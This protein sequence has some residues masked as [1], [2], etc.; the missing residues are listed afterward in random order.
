V[1]DHGY[2]GYAVIVNKKFW[3]GLPPDIRTTL[4]GAMQEATSTA[5]TSPSRKRSRRWRRSENPA[6]R[7][8]SAHAAGKARWKKALLP[9]HAQMADKIGKD[10]IQSIYQATGFD[11]NKLSNRATAFEPLAS[12][13]FGAEVLDRLESG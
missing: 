8:S 10:L 12:G 9:V 5:T 3:E 1:S 6:R 4:E 11:P 7:R 13:N 2:V